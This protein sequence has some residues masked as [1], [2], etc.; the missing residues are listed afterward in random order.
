MVQFWPVVSASIELEFFGRL[1][2][3]QSF[4]EFLIY[5]QLAKRNIFLRLY[6]KNTK[7]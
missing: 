6:V 2:E 3:I 4:V 7:F 5:L 1:K